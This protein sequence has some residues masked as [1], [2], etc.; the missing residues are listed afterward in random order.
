M[1]DLVTRLVEDDEHTRVVQIGRETKDDIHRSSFGGGRLA[2]DSPVPKCPKELELERVCRENYEAFPPGFDARDRRQKI[3]TECQAKIVEATAVRDKIVEKAT[4]K[5][6]KDV[7]LAKQER[8]KRL[9]KDHA[10]TS[11]FIDLRVSKMASFGFLYRE[12]WS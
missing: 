4:K 3:E 8:D 10:F 11:A 7:V 5:Y 2:A 12:V 1:K 9:E 6:E